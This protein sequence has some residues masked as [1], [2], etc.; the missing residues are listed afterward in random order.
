MNRFIPFF[1]RLLSLLVVFLL[2]VGTVLWTGSLLGNK[3]G[4]DAVVETI[5]HATPPNEKQ[6]GQLGIDGCELQVADSAAW[7]VLSSK[8]EEMGVVIATA[9]Y[10]EGVKG[11]AGPTPLYL[12]VDAEERLKAVVI[13]E[14]SETQSFLERAADGIFAQIL[15]KPVAEA[16]NT[17]VDAVSGATY[18][19]N[20]LVGNIKNTLKVRMAHTAEAGTAPAI[21]WSKTIAVAIVLLLGAIVAWRYRGLRP[22]RVGILFLNVIVVGF[23][24]GQFL[25]LSLLRGW[26]QNGTDVLLYLPTLLMLLVAIILPLFG[27]RHHYCTWVCP[28]GSLQELAWLVPIPKLAVSPNVY[29]WMRLVRMIV[30]MLLLFCLWLGFG[31]DILNYEPF[32][33]FLLDVTLPAV[34]LLA[35]I[36]VLLG[37]FVPRPWCKCICPLGALFDMAEDEG[38]KAK[39]TPL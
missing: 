14:N 35:G 31:S 15:G 16:A 3:I 20:A 27:R 21:G 10:A 12:Y 6:I 22:L 4:G 17:K 24:C 39:N 36:F 11:F 18:T 8:G 30:L 1:E 32:S 13:A 38:R 23:W 26:I 28:Y 9:P 25:S 29:K 33:A 19:S 37:L 2:L 34:L 5:S 7:N